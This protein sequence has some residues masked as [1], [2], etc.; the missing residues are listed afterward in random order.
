M[1]LY[2]LHRVWQSHVVLSPNICFFTCLPKTHAPQA[3]KNNDN[4]V[5]M[6]ISVLMLSIMSNIVGKLI[7]DNNYSDLFMFII[8]NRCESPYNLPKFSFYLGYIVM[9]HKRSIFVYC[10]RNLTNSFFIGCDNLLCSIS[11]TTI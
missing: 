9:L 4:T 2:V 7:T 8:H 1:F 10:S 11:S 5:T 3:P 6:I